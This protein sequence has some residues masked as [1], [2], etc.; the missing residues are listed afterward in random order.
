MKINFEKT[1]YRMRF[2]KVRGWAM[3]KGLSEV[4]VRLILSGK[5]PFD[6]GPKYDRIIEELR[7]EGWLVEEPETPQA[8]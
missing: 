7:K 3:E 4:T 1:R 6:S 2:I 8:A 5:Y